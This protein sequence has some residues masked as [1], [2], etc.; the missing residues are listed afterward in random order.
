MKIPS[1][2]KRTKNLSLRERWIRPQGEDGEGKSLPIF[3]HAK[4]ATLSVAFGA[5]S[6]K[7]RA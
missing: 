3:K 6:P 2:E 5:S 4:I 7:G 1:L